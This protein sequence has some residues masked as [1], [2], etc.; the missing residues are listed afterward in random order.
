MK[1]P[2]QIVQTILVTE[3]GSHLSDALNQ[4]TFKVA[5]GANK[6]EI[7]QAVEKL[8]NVKVAA[9]NV[10]NRQGKRKRVRSAKAGR[11]P[12]WKKAIVTLK[13]GKINIL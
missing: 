6:I 7:R 1:D 4:Y 9:V 13:E 11:R 2:Y 12:D 5:R 3:K 10:M 8:F